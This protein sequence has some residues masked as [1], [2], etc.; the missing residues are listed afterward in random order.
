MLL[1]MARPALGVCLPPDMQCLCR[2]DSVYGYRNTGAG[3][4]GH[5]LLK[6]APVVSL[7]GLLCSRHRLLFVWHS[8]ACDSCTLK[9]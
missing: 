9:V 8:I 7:D 3:G 2:V 6:K 4:L 5:F 1:Q